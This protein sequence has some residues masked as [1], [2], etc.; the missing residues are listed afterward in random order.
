MSKTAA[1][2]VGIAKYILI[3]EIIAAVWAKGHLYRGCVE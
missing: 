1:A 2:G 3:L